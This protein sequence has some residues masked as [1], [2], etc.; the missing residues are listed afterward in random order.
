M[1]FP[2]RSSG[3][4]GRLGVLCCAA[5]VWAGSALALEL[6]VAIARAPVLETPANTQAAPKRTTLLVDF[7]FA[8]AREIC[9]RL[10][11]KCV[12][13]Y[14]PF[15]AIIPGVESKRCELG[16]G[17]H[18]RTKTRETQVAFSSPVWYSS[19]RLLTTPAV[20]ERFARQSAGEVTLGMLRDVRITA[21]SA[22]QQH[23]YLRSIADA[24]RLQ[25]LDLATAQE[26]IQALQREQA[27]FALLY[28]LGAYLELDA[29]VQPTPVFMGPGIIDHELGGSVHIVLAREDDA[30]RRRVDLAL[31]EMRRDGSYPRLWRRHFPFDLY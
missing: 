19:S 21:I 23:I 6:R 13:T 17:N 26:C 29:T 9:R 18:L 15:A 10:T 28:G 30:L 12:Y 2:A 1:C 22:S 7:N 5:L 20:A 8:L 16:F 3:V 4:C 14:Q 11:A 24:Q 25:V 27:D 31:D